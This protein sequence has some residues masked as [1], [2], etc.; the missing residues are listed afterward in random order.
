MDGVTYPLREVSITNFTN[1]LWIF[2]CDKF[3]KIIVGKIF[4]RTEVP[5]NIFYCNIAIIIWV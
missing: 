4:V 3:L 2:V 5:K 1:F